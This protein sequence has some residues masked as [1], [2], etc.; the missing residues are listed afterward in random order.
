MKIL[1]LGAVLKSVAIA[2]QAYSLFQFSRHLRN[3]FGENRI[4]ANGLVEA[5]NRKAM[6]EEPVF[7]LN[8][9]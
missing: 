3:V 4:F 1:L 6:R 2:T 5:R 9:N 7:T 8:R